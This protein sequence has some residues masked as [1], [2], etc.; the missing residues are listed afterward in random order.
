M[1]NTAFTNNMTGTPYIN[2][3]TPYMGVNTMVQPKVPSMTQLLSPEEMAQLKQNNTGFN[4]NVDPKDILK[5]MCTHKQNNAYAIV[6][7]GDGSVTCTVCGETFTPVFYE[8][9]QIDHVL[10]DV[11]NI[12]NTIK[13]VYTDI[14]R[15]LGREYMGL[16][17]LVMKLKPLYKVAMNNFNQYTNVSN[18][19]N[20]SPYGNAFATLNAITNGYN[21]GYGYPMGQPAMYGQPMMNPMAQPMMYD[22]NQFNGLNPNPLA[23]AQSNIPMTPSY[24]QTPP[25]A[26]PFNSMYG[27]PMMNPMAQQPV[28]QPQPNSYGVAAPTQP[29]A[30]TPGTNPNPYNIPT[31]YV[32]GSVPPPTAAPAPSNAPGDVTVSETLKV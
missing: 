24:Q 15:E 5:A 17:P 3:G 30:P 4:I 22:P 29:V 8:S 6:E 10:D 1:E 7:N 16:E 21:V 9:D 27:Q 11:K 23:V 18:T 28:P 14:P 31:S 20:T 25:V 12:F 19:T 13:L 2:Y 32:P 26:N